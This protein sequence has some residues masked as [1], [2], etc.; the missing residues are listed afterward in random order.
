MASGGGAVA[1]T[2][3]C[4][5]TAGHDDLGRSMKLSGQVRCSPQSALNPV[6]VEDH[7][8]L[9]ADDF[10]GVDPKVTAAEFR[11]THSTALTLIV[12]AVATPPS[13]LWSRG[14]TCP[15]SATTHANDIPQ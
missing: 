14:R 6:D 15:C 5:P 13:L 9:N 3:P 4:Q 7:V 8:K 11:I 12:R 1:G 2:A 10:P